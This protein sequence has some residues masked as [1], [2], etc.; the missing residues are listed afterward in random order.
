MPPMTHPVRGAFSKQKRFGE[1]ENRLALL[2]VPQRRGVA[3][4]DGC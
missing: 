4:V 2:N 1:R 3:G